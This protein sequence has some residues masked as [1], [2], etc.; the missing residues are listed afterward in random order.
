MEEKR[1]PARTS[2]LGARRKV[3]LALCALTLCAKL[4][5]P[6]AAEVLRPWIIGREDNRVMAAFAALGGS[7]EQGAPLREAVQ[8][9]YM[10]MTGDGLS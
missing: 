5:C 2:R 9:F 4:Y 7:M 6:Q 1:T 10:E 3:S 8:A